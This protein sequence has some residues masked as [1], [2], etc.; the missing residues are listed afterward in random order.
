MED[1]QDQNLETTQTDSPDKEQERVEKVASMSRRESYEQARK[2]LEGKEPAAEKAAPQAEE[3]QA[4]GWMSKEEK[5]H[6][7]SG[8]F[9]EVEK[10]YNRLATARGN[11]ARRLQEEKSVWEKEKSESA[12]WKDISQKMKPYLEARRKEG[13]PDEQALLDALTLVDQIKNDPNGAK[14]TIDQLSGGRVEEL[15]NKN[16]LSNQEKEEL[17]SLQSEVKN[18]KLE[19]ERDLHEKRSSYYDDLFTRVTSKKTSSGD[20]L[21]PDLNNSQL[22]LVIAR[23]IGT[24]ISNPSF[25]QTVLERYPDANDEKIVE[26][27]Y[28]EMGCRVSDEGG[29]PRTLQDKSK[30]IIR[31][32]IAAASTPG[33]STSGIVAGKRKTLTRREAYEAAKRDLEGH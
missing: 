25:V 16:N 9:K 10:A 21:Y 24:R 12:P 29:S 28:K 18:L 14:A 27:A 15:E 31:S 33:R 5:E 13:V 4:P 26:E 3:V 7:K 32:R 30:H 6:Y 19:R 17:R 1:N 8:N 2:D 20:N 22:G 23:E 11:E